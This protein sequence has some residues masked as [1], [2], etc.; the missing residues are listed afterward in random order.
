MR[1]RARIGPDPPAVRCAERQDP[2]IYGVL[3]LWIVRRRSTGPL[4][5]G[6]SFRMITVRRSRIQARRLHIGARKRSGL[7]HAGKLTY[8]I[9]PLNV[10]SL[11]RSIRAHKKYGNHPAGVI[12]DVQ[13]LCHRTPTPPERVPMRGTRSWFHVEATCQA[14]QCRSKRPQLCGERGGSRNGCPPS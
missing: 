7:R 4:A 6:S 14:G 9:K 2:A 8:S 12:V 11:D 10:E 3:F 1:R 5:G 13:F